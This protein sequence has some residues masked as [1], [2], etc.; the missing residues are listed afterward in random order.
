MSTIGLAFADQAGVPE[1]AAEDVAGHI[2][3]WASP[4]R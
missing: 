1:A 4:L 2:D 3:T